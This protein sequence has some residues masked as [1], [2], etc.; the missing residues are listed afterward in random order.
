M[1]DNSINN[2]PY[3]RYWNFSEF[4]EASKMPPTDRDN[5]ILDDPEFYGV[6]NKEECYAIMQNGWAHINS[7]VKTLLPP[8]NS[9]FDTDGAEYSVERVS[10]QSPEYMI[11]ANR[12]KTKVF[13]SCTYPCSIRKESLIFFGASMYKLLSSNKF[14]LFAYTAL[15]DKEIRNY[16][17]I[18]NLKELSAALHPSFLRVIYLTYTETLPKD[19]R[20]K[21]GF[22][23]GSGYGRPYSIPLR[24]KAIV[25]PGVDYNFSTL[26]DSDKWVHS[27]VEDAKKSILRTI[28]KDVDSNWLN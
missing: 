16:I 14:S 20:R 9:K 21:Y 5:I 12:D 25:L 7:G 8:K 13:F 10:M 6:R 26:E 27:K 22:Y 23:P 11:R 15:P 3:Q 17:Q 19:L 28:D 4:V 1:K 24:Y 18:S 2:L